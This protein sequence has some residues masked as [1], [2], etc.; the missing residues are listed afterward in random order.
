MNLIELT[1]EE[2]IS[3]E[4]GTTPGE[5]TSLANDAFYYST[6]V[7]LNFWYGLKTFGEGA[8]EGAAWLG[9]NGK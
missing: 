8:N 9:A 4:G 6:K 1:S 3:I 7:V 5:G 2:L